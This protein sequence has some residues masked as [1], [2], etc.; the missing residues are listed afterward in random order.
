MGKDFVRQCFQRKQ[1]RYIVM[2]GDSQGV[3]YSWGMWST[4]NKTL[5]AC[6]ETPAMFSHC[7]LNS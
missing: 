7:F 6:N 1:V 5:Q 4:L 3:R 2:M